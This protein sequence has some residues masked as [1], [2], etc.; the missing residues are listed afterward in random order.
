MDIV[1][2]YSEEYFFKPYIYPETW[3]QDDPLRQLINLY[4]V[5]NI[6]GALLYLSCAT[7][8]F[9]LLFDHQL[10]KHP[11]F[12]KDQVKLE[13][14]YTL[15]SVP[16]ISIPT[17]A[18][19]FLEVRGHSKLYDEV[20]RTPL[21]WMKEL[22]NFVF[23]ILFTD[24][25]IYWIHRFLH[26]RTIYKH[27]HKPH[28]IWKVPSPFASHAFHPVDGFLQS[29]PYHIFVFLFPLHKVT[30]LGL[31]VIVNMWSTSIHDG[32]FLVPKVLQPVINGAA[33]HTV[34][35]LYFDYNYGQY[36][37]LW[38][39]IGGSYLDPSTKLVEETDVS[40]KNKLN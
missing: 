18:L 40:W 7:A 29:A 33:N 22:A 37:T 20:E 3:R 30:Y 27:F 12:L 31:Y 8:S 26:H 4:V 21:G 17:V 34:H 14:Q 19:F 24:M 32:L 25:L 35:H 23:F 38:D 15:K 28:H 10:M 6:G 13:I 1:L 36:F 11:L 9:Y 2:E 39:R 16:W 5:T